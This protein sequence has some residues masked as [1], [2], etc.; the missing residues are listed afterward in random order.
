MLWLAG[1]HDPGVSMNTIYSNL[2]GSYVFDSNFRLKDKILFSKSDQP[3]IAKL[4][5]QGKALDSEKKLATKHK[6]RL[7]SLPRESSMTCFMSSDM[8]ASLT[9][10]MRSM[11]NF[12]SLHQANIAITK[13]DIRSSFSNDT[14]I[15]QSVNTIKELDKMITMLSSRLREWYGYG[16]PEVARDVRDLEAFA[17]LVATTTIEDA[18][19]ATKTLPEERMGAKLQKEDCTAMKA[20]A[21]EI[22]NLFSLRNAQ[23]EYLEVL[24][25]KECPNIQ[26]VAGTM[27]GA[28]LLATAGSLRALSKFP[29]S[30][31]QTL[32]AEKALFR[33][34]T[35]KS[36]PPKHGHLVN[37]PLV[38]STPKNK[39]GR[40]AR[41]LADK[42]SIAAK[43]DYFKGAFVGDKLR[44]QV[45]VKLL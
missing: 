1:V 2:T 12:R 22:L 35:T 45:E 8:F 41:V 4:L 18:Y 20:M 28:K 7:F 10:I 30:T 25:R 39:R 14:Y 15:V 36:R 33:H 44:K 27:I 38:A 32:G 43:V 42:L 24:M 11:D 9:N 23:E 19:K 5:H 26:A 29:A 6:A 3:T 37:H 16:A 17:R 31:V 40:A 21:E 13:R 34:L